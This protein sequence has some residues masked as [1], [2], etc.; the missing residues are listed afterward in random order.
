MKHFEHERYSKVESNDENFGEEKSLRILG[1]ENTLQEIQ[2]DLEIVTA[3]T[4]ISRNEVKLSQIY[5]A[6][7]G[8]LRGIAGVA[9]FA[10]AS[11]HAFSQE[12]DTH[13]RDTDIQ[14]TQAI[15]TSYDK[16]LEQKKLAES[17]VGYNIYNEAKKVGRSIELSVVPE[18]PEVVTIVFL[19]QTHNTDEEQNWRSKNKISKS[20]KEIAKYLTATTT[21]DTK[22]FVE[23][24][25]SQHA[26][27]DVYRKMGSDLTKAS[28]AEE[29][30]SIYKLY[31]EVDLATKNRLAGEKLESFGFVEVSPLMYKKGNI[32]YLLPQTGMFPAD[33][34]RLVSNDIESTIGSSVLPLHAQG[35]I[36]L[37]PA[38]I[39][40]D[41]GARKRQ[42]KIMSHIESQV[43]RLS[44]LLSPFAVDFSKSLNN[45][46]YAVTYKNAISEISK[47][48]FTMFGFDDG[49]PQF[50]KLLAEKSFCKENKEC[51]EITKDLVE[52]QIPALKEN[53]FKEREDEA[54]ELIAKKAI[55]SKQVVVPLVYGSAHDFTRAV[56][57]WNENHPGVNDVRFNLITIKN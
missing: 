23:N 36:Q 37:E 20:Q 27:F 30:L 48:T 44:S 21:S 12:T 15:E 32:E 41:F 1:I 51:V 25:F 47:N 11:Q 14:Q 24:M 8:R 9:L 34:A 4:L 7:S 2:P 28:T 31:F 18:K 43:T 13:T 29:V 49:T 52:Q 53:I 56:K 54:V 5:T 6:L 35:T 40:F 38:E 57:K 45:T 55:G 19:G 46:S 50:F 17:L 10:L 16:F 26:A 42:A 3:E 22:V 33:K 39:G